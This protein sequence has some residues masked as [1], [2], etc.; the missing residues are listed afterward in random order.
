MDT[1]FQRA[2]VAQLVAHLADILG[3][4]SSNLVAVSFSN[5]R[6]CLLRVQVPEDAE[7][8]RGRPQAPHAHEVG[9]V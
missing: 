6:Q 7:P 8:G 2:Q 4:G 9:Q 5:W 1:D 3:D